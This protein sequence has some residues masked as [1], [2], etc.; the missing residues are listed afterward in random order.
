MFNQPIGYVSSIDSIM[1][2]SWGLQVLTQ[3]AGKSSGRRE[4]FPG[5]FQ[6]VTAHVEVEG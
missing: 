5:S 3:Y 4:S 6:E 2:P 1:A